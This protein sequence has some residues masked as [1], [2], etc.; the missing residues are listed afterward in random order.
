M[1]PTL[2]SAGYAVD[3]ELSAGT[4]QEAERKPGTCFAIPRISKA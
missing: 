2:S 3:V 4:P 1:Q